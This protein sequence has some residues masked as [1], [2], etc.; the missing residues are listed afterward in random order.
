MIE[1]DESPEYASKE[2]MKKPFEEE[3]MANKYR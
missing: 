2:M 1:Y 3:P